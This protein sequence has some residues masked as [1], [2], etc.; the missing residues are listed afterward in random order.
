[1]LATAAESH[2]RRRAFVALGSNLGDRW[3]HLRT[4]VSYLPDVAGLSG[5][6]ETE[7]VGGPSQGPY[8]NMV[9]ELY[10]E[11]SPQDLLR[12]ARAA[13]AAA[14]RVRVERW[15]PRTLD[16]DILLVGELQITSPDLVVPHP[17]MWDRGFV[18]V[19]LE[20]LA[21]ELVAGRITEQHREGFARG[22]APERE[23][24]VIVVHEADD[25]RG[26][27]DEARSKGKG[28]GFLPT[29]GA[30]HGGH[31]SNIRKMAAECSF[32]AISIFVN[33][34]QFGPGEDFQAY[35]RDLDGDLAQAEEAG[36]DL[37]LVPRAMFA[38]EP[39]A[40]VR[41][42]RLDD[43]LE[44]RRRPGHFEGVATIVT[45]LL[46]L[47]GPCFAYFGEK[48]F[49]QL[50]IVRK[51]VE[52]LSL[53]AAVVAC[54]TVREP[55][56]LALS[57][58][59]RYLTPEERRAAPVLYWSLLAGKRAI[60]EEGTTDAEGVRSAMLEVAARERLVRLD[61]VAVADPTTLEEVKAVDRAVRLLVAGWVGSARL[62]D[63]VAASSG[64]D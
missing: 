12:A 47:A 32:G 41:V 39:L 49:Q 35:P 63:N 3:A 21:P 51:L 30:L 19:P 33:P 50:V 37:V 18:L 25:F 5:V 60:E 64:E 62:I 16:V 58:R 43:I 57:S 1:M 23:H 59:N 9:A 27:L 22:P 61:Y 10:T 53:P 14:A 34:L 26:L 52:D 6:Y 15:G 28:V 38:E 29:M 45:K 54:P 55:D 11:A 40:T 8:L 42:K 31:R 46:A 17:R 4:G 48:D 2:A 56:G 20:E 13:E 24:A 7:P 44:G 36:A